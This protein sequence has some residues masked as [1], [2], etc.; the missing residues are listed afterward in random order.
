M[1]PVLAGHF[2]V[3]RQT[4]NTLLSKFVDF[5]LLHI[6]T[7]LIR[8]LLNTNKASQVIQIEFR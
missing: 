7:V 8:I 4:H 2:F 1:M 5:L 3:L 6:L